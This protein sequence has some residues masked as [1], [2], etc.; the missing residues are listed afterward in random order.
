MAAAEEEIII[1]KIGGSS[2]THKAHEETLNQQNLDWFSKLI[3]ASVDESFLAPNANAKTKDHTNNIII[4]G[5]TSPKPKFIVVHG[6]GSFG[7]HS[8]KRHG[9]RCG[10]AA[11]LDAK[12][13]SPTLQHLPRP[14]KK[15]KLNNG[16]AHPQQE[17]NHPGTIIISNSSSKQR[18]QMQALSKTRQSVQKLNAAMIQSLLKHGV[19]AVGISPGMTIPM[20]RAHGATTLLPDNNNNNNNNNNNGETGAVRDSSV[21]GMKYLCQSIH[22]SLEAGL[23]PVLH[24]D[25]CLL[26]DGVQAGILGGDTIAEGIATL[27]GESIPRDCHTGGDFRPTTTNK[28]HSSDAND[29]KLACEES[30]ATNNNGNE[31]YGKKISRVIFITDVGGVYTSDPKSDTDASLIRSLRIGKRTGEVT[32]EDKNDGNNASGSATTSAAAAAAAL[33]VSGSSHAHDVTGGLKVRK[34]EHDSIHKEKK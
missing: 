3:A 10:K 19:N 33:N 7:H 2:I 22:Q 28:G 8:A 31:K 25:A 4:K 21:E 27:W 6:A 24:G 9:L 20:L 15:C 30:N 14:A 17:E 32:I 16:N 29:N 13:K 34:K 12:F 23:V 5:G 18:C 11:F 1:L 26:Y